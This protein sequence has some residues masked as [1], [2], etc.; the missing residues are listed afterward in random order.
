MR[1]LTELLDAQDP[2][3]PR[4]RA[5]LRACPHDVDPLPCAPSDA[6][7]ALLALQVTTRSLLGAV[8][9]ATGGLWVD[10]GWL[11]VLGAGCAR[12]PRAIDAWNQI[13]R[14]P[15][16]REGLLVAD[17][18][19]GGFFAWRSSTRTIAYLAPDTLAWEDTEMGY[20]AWL[21]AMLSPAFA[22]FYAPLRWSG[23]RDDVATVRGDQGLS[24]YPPLWS[25]EG[26]AEQATSRRA[27]P[28]EELWAL[29]GA[30]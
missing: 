19:L 4:L 3:L 21:C 10:G 5:A 1:T 15:R 24:V 8:A 27:V 7:R 9:H 13:D 25:A 17:D 30:G 20:E 23:W 14:A 11:R 22:S 12:L 26:R 16:C 18:V 2:A 28:I 6:D 29:H